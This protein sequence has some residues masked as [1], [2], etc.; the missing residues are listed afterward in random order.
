MD[1]NSL[2]VYPP[3]PEQPWQFP[4]QLHPLRDAPGFTPMDHLP[5]YTRST[6]PPHL[7]HTTVDRREM[8][9]NSSNLCPQDAHLKS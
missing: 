8:V 5:S 6:G 4:P 9:V 7:G 2:R 1:R 3:Q